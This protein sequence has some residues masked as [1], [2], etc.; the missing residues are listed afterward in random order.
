MQ[1]YSNTKQ[2]ELSADTVYYK[3]GTIVHQIWIGPK[4]PPQIWMKTVQDFCKEFGHTYKL[5]DNEEVQTLNLR[6]YPGIYDLYEFY[7]NSETKDKWAAQADIL[8]YILLYE[9]G[10]IFVDADS[11]IVNGPRFDRLLREFRSGVLCG[12]ENNKGLIAN[13]VILTDQY[14]HILKKAIDELPEFVADKPNKAV[15]EQTGPG[16]ITHIFRKYQLR[17]P[18]DLI[19]VPKH[20]FYPIDWHGIED[21]NAHTKMK[22]HPDTM[23]FQ[24]GYTT[25]NFAAKLEQG[26]VKSDHMYIVLIALG[27]LYVMS[28]LNRSN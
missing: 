16:F 6:S 12:A 19:V 2:L 28:L 11:A 7:L 18:T 1:V 15:W 3:K 21:P 5:W 27:A 26:K 17:Y 10:G 9:R 13:G 24:Y 14:N 8:R 4:P 22:F 20:W 23:M 25:N